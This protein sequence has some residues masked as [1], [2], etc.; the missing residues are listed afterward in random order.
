MSSE[1]LGTLGI[2]H[3][4]AKLDADGRVTEAGTSEALEAMATKIVDR[5]TA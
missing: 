1:V 4:R 5:L 2:A 3:V